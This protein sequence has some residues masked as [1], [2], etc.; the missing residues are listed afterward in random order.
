MTRI[1]KRNADLAIK[2]VTRYNAARSGRG[3]DRLAR[4]NGVEEVGGSNPLAPTENRSL[5]APVFVFIVATG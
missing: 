1:I 3:A 2:L 4:F 5:R